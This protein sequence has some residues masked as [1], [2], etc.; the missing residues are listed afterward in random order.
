MSYRFGGFF[1]SAHALPALFSPTGD[2]PVTQ[3]RLQAHT[4][5][6]A[7]RWTLQFVNKSDEIVRQFGGQ[8]V[9]PP[10]VLWDGKDANG[11]PL[12]DGVYRY[13]LVVYD[14]EGRVLTDTTRSVE[15]S[16]SGPQG[17]VPVQVQ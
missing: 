10:H 17:A 9:P 14:R 8:G 3:V 2:Q 12:A 5:A 4:K 11:L 6:D 7:D 1:A 13:Q 16:T 15:I